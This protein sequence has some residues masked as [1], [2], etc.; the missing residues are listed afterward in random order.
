MESE[1]IIYNSSIQ[2][3]TDGPRVVKRDGSFEDVSFKKIGN[4]METLVENL[5]VDPGIIVECVKKGVV[6]MMKTSDIDMFAA[7]QC[8][9]LTLVHTDYSVLGGRLLVSNLYP[10]TH[11]SF[12]ECTKYMYNYINPRTGRHTPLVVKKYAEFVEAHAKELDEMIDNKRDYEFTYYG[13]E[14]LARSYLIKS[15]A[16]DRKVLERPQ[17]MYARVAIW[18]WMDVGT[19]EEIQKCYDLLSTGKISHASPTM[20]G[21][22]TISNG[23]SSCF[24]TG[25]KSDSIQGIFQSV[26][27]C[28]M[29][30]KGAGGIGIS[31]SNVRASGSYIESTNG[32]SNGIPPMLRV[33]D[34]VCKYVDQGG[35]KRPGAAAVYTEM[36]HADIIEILDL[37]TATGDPES[38]TKNLFYGLW[39][40]DLFM[41]RVET[42]EKWTLMCPGECPGLDEVW[43]EEY[44]ALY[45]KYESEGRGKETIEARKLW[46]LIVTTQMKT[47]GPYMMYKDAC[48]RKSNQQHLG[49]IKCSNLCTEI[50]EFTDPEN[51]AVC[52]L[53][54]VVLNKCVVEAESSE[55]YGCDGVC[56]AFDFDRLEVY[57]TQAT[58]N[59]DRV[60]EITNYPSKEARN[61]NE[62]QRPMGIGVQG[63][64]DV[65]A[66][67]GIPYNSLDSMQLN[68][69]IFETMYYVSMTVSMELARKR[70]AP[71][72]GFKGSP[73]SR[74]IFQFD[75]WEGHVHPEPVFRGHVHD[76]EK[77]RASVLEHG[78]VNSLLLAP[79]PTASTAQILGNN[80]TFEAFTSNLYKRRVLSGTF[81]VVNKHLMRDLGSTWTKDIETQMYKYEG[82]VQ[83]VVGISKRI[84]Q[85][86][87]T[88]WEYPQS[89]LLQMAID[90]GPYID[91][92]QS[93]NV[94]MIKPNVQKL[95]SLHF[96]GWKSGAKGSMYYLRQ[97]A[98][99]TALH[100]T[101]EEE[102]ASVEGISSPASSATSASSG[103]GGR[104]PASSDA[105]SP[106]VFCGM[107]EG[108][109]S[110]AL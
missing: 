67:L 26:S 31:V 89:D 92:W 25:I 80:E 106:I 95:T 4:R 3:T 12:S 84:K 33:L 110:C 39:I 23:L 71:Y 105:Q 109:A 14:T 66:L 48:N 56:R 100:F 79:M 36:H 28:A 32:E 5:K 65:C 17:Y 35:N 43:G 73:L 18:I 81:P 27:E 10:Q 64:A 72:P 62:N 94:H 53:A 37:K 2:K 40:C 38:K 7:R 59:L 21:S 91:Q 58:L 70:G 16:P 29:I 107:E 85:V 57:T 41:Q 101:R 55:F 51:T 104:S 20:F 97:K 96:M 42:N 74:G 22:A 93:F 60:I 88:V 1:F 50:V 47:S 108:C 52:N 78:T 49:T 9:D 30:S 87:K 83:E 45:T 44:N 75:M 13:F 19:V 86:Y 90:R 6:D 98:A 68:K 63:Y 54:A 34:T 24:L 69:E 103:G 8:R 77:L 82:S 46:N 102:A 76:W 99:T 61:S 11:D 15:A